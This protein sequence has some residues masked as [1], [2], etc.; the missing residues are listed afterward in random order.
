MGQEC[1]PRSRIEEKD[2]RGTD[3]PGREGLGG[4]DEMLVK[5]YVDDHPGHSWAVQEQGRD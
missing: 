5:G 3:R 2:C 1:H 4:K